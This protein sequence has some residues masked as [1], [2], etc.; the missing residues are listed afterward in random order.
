MELFAL[1]R[2]EQIGQITTATKVEVIERDLG[3][4]GWLVEMPLGAAG[5]VGAAIISPATLWPGIELHDPGTG[6][7]FGGYLT[8][9]TIVVDENGVETLRLV[10][11]DFQTD[12]ANYL[13]W[14][15]AANPE[16]WWVQTVGGTLPRTSDLHNSVDLNCGPAVATIGRQPIYGLEHGPD[17]AGG[18]PLPRRLKGE[19]LMAVAKALLW[20]TAWTARL[21]L[22]RGDDGSPV[23]LF[24]TP[25]RPLAPVV[26]DVKRGS[27]GS[28]ELTWQAAAVTDC[29]GMGAEITPV[30]VPDAR[31]VLRNYGFQAD[32]RE[33]HREA[34]INRPA[35]DD[36][37]ALAT[38]VNEAVEGPAGAWSRS[39][40]VDSV[41]V[42]GWGRDID[43]GWLVDV[44]LGSAFTPSTVRLPVVASTL[45]FS[46]EA[47]WI[48]TAD[49][50]AE[51]L[52]GP[53]SIYATIARARYQLR[54]LEADIR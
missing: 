19:P 54:Q 50:G 34:F 5:E 10:G 47:G 28:V 33:R 3:A 14:P 40:K 23:M 49:V 22:I 48:R 8:S 12:L 37:D 6:W 52:S 39:V 24:E 4:G 13:E 7:R 21:H 30:V 38:D 2:F 53:A 36:I 46:P 11:S 15:V 31:Q 32:W 1:D 16:E 20:G 9:W 44:H 42:D 29:I 45:T 26:L 25:G 41:R 43:L 27:F 17:P 18:D 35:S 51:S